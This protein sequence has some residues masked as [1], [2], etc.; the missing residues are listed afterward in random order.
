MAQASAPQFY[1]VVCVWKHV[2]VSNTDRP[3]VRPP[4]SRDKHMPSYNPS[5]VIQKARLSAGLTQHELGTRTNLGGRAIKDIEIG[6][7]IP[8]LHVIRKI[9]SVLDV[10]L[11]PR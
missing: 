5:L 8:S 2:E 4:T 10:Q 6:R 7:M 9:E 11:L 1:P 3:R